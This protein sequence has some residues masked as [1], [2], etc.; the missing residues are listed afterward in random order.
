MVRKFAICSCAVLVLL[1]LSPPVM[2]A[3]QRSRRAAATESDR[4]AVWAELMTF[5]GD[6]GSYGALSQTDHSLQTAWQAERAGYDNSTI[7][8][9]LFHDVRPPLHGDIVALSLSFSMR[10]SACVRVPGGVEAGAAIRREN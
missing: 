9:G 2:P 1:V 10:M 4:E 8:A 3:A 7:A 5:Y 6:G